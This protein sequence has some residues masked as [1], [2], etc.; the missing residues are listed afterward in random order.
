M[1]QENARQHLLTRLDLCERWRTSR[2]TLKRR[3][4]DGTLIALKLGRFVRYRL[5][6]VERIEKESEVVR[7]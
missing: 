3:E 5:S 4:R 7:P 1:E 2:E 6:D